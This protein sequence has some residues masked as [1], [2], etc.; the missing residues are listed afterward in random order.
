MKDDV[1]VV[2][3]NFILSRLLY[4]AFAANLGLLCMLHPGMK[5]LV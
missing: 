1:V 2:D 4:I 3:D 5:P